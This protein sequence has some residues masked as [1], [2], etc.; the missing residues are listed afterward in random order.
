LFDVFHGISVINNIFF[1]ETEGETLDDA[2][3]KMAQI[4]NTD[5]YMGMARYWDSAEKT[6]KQRS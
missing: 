4:L 1:V 5:V 6:Y 3:R 2:S